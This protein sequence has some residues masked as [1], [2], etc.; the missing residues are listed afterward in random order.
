MLGRRI[1]ALGSAL[2]YVN[3]FAKSE[4]ARLGEALRAAFTDARVGLDDLLARPIEAERAPEQ[5]AT[6]AG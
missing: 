4:G 1:S 5:E 6:D 3:P 2:V